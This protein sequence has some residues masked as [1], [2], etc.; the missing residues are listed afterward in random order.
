[1]HI[2]LFTTRFLPNVGGMEYVIHYLAEALTE[3]GV[4]VTV[5]A[6]RTGKVDDFDFCYRLQRYGFSFKGSFRLGVNHLSAWSTLHR[7]HTSLPLDVINFH[8]VSWPPRYGLSFSKS[9]N[10]PVVMTPHGQ[11]IQR[12][13]EIG[14]GLRLDPDWDLRVRRH[15]NASDAVTAISESVKIELDFVAPEKIFLIPNGIH[16]ERFSKDPSRYLNQLLTI[17]S[18]HRIILSVG[19]NHLKKGYVYGIEATAE[20]IEKYRVTDF[21]YVLIGRGVSQH[22]NLVDRLSMHNHIRLVEEMQ[23]SR[24]SQAYNS[25]DIFFSP[26]I[27][28][29]LSLVSIEAMACGLPLIVTEVPGNLDIVRDNP[30]CGLIVGNKNVQQMAKALFDLLDDNERRKKM[31]AT[32]F[33]CSKKYDW[34]QIAQRYLEVYRAVFLENNS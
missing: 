7:Q 10:L 20:L 32:G 19:R 8:S 4:D 31:G 28:E 24:L 6:K 16:I 13:K 25:S 14:Y 15:I 33:S 23:P 12:I 34:S 9:H 11:D 26:S 5:F 18:D 17:P 22:Q 21:C 1:M 29:G 30:G 3:L 27:I 2:G